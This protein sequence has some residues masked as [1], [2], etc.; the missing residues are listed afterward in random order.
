MRPN[1]AI[2][3]L[4][5]ALEQ[6]IDANLALIAITGENPNEANRMERLQIIGL[7]LEET[8]VLASRL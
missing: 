2:A 7:R 5:V 8:A 1:E 3:A 6:A 4:L